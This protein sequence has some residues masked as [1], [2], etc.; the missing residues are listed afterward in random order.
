MVISLVI[1][2]SMLMRTFK[3]I[4]EQAGFKFSDRKLLA[5]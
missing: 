4:C 1:L 3:Q 5:D 2:Q